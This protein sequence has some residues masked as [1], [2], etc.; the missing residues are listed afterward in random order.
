MDHAGGAIRVPMADAV[1]MVG[2]GEV[3]L[4]E[5]PIR[6][7]V[8]IAEQV[9]P[10]TLRHEQVNVHEVDIADRPLRPGDDAF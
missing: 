9:L 7:T 2:T 5:V 6:K 4:G 8:E 1:L 3:E 10:V